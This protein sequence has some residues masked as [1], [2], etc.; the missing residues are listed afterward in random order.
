VTRGQHTYRSNEIIT[1]SGS[2]TLPS[3]DARDIFGLDLY[4][5]KSIISG[6][7][8]EDLEAPAFEVDCVMA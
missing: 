2:N 7:P 8:D 1:P 4:Q 6:H 5:V 3:N